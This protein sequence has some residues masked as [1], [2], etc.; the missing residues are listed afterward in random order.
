MFAQPARRSFCLPARH[1]GRALVEPA[2]QT[3]G[4]LQLDRGG[5]LLLEARERALPV[6]AVAQP[7]HVVD[8]GLRREAPGEGHVIEPGPGEV[9]EVALR[10][11]RR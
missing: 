11:C 7:L 2:L 10:S 8:R 9:A 6:E 3:D 1:V 4:A 5:E